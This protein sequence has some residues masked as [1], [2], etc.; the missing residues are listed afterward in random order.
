MMLKHEYIVPFLG[1]CYDFKYATLPSLVS[2]YFENGNINVYLSREVD[3]GLKER[4]KIVS[5]VCVYTLNLLYL[6]ALEALPGRTGPNIFA[7]Q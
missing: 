3:L 1:I 6:I 7:Q 4:L 2:P 5:L